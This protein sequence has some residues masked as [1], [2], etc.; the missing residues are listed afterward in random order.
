MDPLL[1]HVSEYMTSGPFALGPREPL[2]NAARLMQKYGV[3]H[4]PVWADGKVVGIVSERDVQLVQALS[5]GHLETTTVEDA[6]TPDPYSVAPDAPLVEVVHHL[7]ERRVGS[8]VVV[9]G[10]RIVGVF[11]T[12]DA[13]RAL[14]EALEGRLSP[15]LG[16]ARAR[17][18]RS[19]RRVPAR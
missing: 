13:M 2:S 17:R 19:S 10:G 3:H 12:A 1:A 4:L 14:V 8:A 18:S 15:Q 16:G 11:T 9:D 7:T 6:M 5:V